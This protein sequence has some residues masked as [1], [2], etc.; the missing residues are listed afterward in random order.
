MI[1]PPTHIRTPNL[2]LL[3]WAGFLVL[4]GLFAATV[5]VSLITP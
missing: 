3:G 5:F 4:V 2:P 1:R